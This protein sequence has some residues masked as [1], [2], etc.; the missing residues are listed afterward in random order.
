MHVLLKPIGRSWSPPV[1]ATV[2]LWSLRWRKEEVDVYNAP[3][4][5][6]LSRSFMLTGYTDTCRE[7]YK[8]ISVIN[9]SSNG[10]IF[11]LCRMFL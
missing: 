3:D 2:L 9:V 8:I 6:S 1:C 5:V 4:N 11:H 10:N 7:R